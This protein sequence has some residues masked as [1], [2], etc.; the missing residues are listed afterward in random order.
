MGA[1]VPF[2]FGIALQ[3]LSGGA[4]IDTE[5]YDSFYEN[6]Q[7]ITDFIV[8]RQSFEIPSEIVDIWFAAYTNPTSLGNLLP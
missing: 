7:N 5:L 6:C 8:F 4:I 1:W 2:S 3:T